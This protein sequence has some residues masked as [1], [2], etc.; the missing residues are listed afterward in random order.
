MQAR[1]QFKL[2]SERY[3]DVSDQVIDKV[4]LLKSKSN[5]DLCSY[6]SHLGK[7]YEPFKQFY[8]GNINGSQL[9]NDKKRV[10]DLTKDMT[11]VSI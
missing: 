9:E 4:E 8:N 2:A 10:L 3:R 1:D 11:N 6:L 5:A 7:V